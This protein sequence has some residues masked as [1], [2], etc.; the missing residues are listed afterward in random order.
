MAGSEIFDKVAPERLTLPP[1][2]II[3]VLSDTKEE[4][5][6]LKSPTDI[7]VKSSK[8]STESP[9]VR[10]VLPIVKSIDE[11]L[12]VTSP[13]PSKTVLPDITP[14]RLTLLAVSSLDAKSITLF[15]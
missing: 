1:D 12:I 10:L 8:E 14:S 6:I 3:I 4:L 9:R 7:D 15:E 13:D 2:C 5:E 11:V